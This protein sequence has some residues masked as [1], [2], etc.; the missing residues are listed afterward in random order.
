MSTCHITSTLGC[1]CKPGESVRRG[2]RSRPQDC[3]VVWSGLKTWLHYLI[4]S[5]NVKFSAGTRWPKLRLARSFFGKASVIMS[6]LRL[7]LWH[8]MIQV[9]VGWW[10]VD[11]GDHVPGISLNATDPPSFVNTSTSNGSSP[12][13][14]STIRSWWFWQDSSDWWFGADPNVSVT[15]P[16]G[17]S[18]PLEGWFIWGFRLCAWVGGAHVFSTP[19][20]GGR[21][22]AHG[23]W[24][25]FIM[26][27]CG[28]W[29]F[30]N[31]WPVVGTASCA[32]MFICM[33]GLTAWSLHVL[34]RFWFCQC[35]RAG[36]RRL[37][38]GDAGPEHEFEETPV[39]RAFQ[40]LTLTG[41]FG[42][43]AADT[44]FY[45]KGVRGRGINRK[46]HDLVVVLDSGVA[47]LQVDQERRG[48][49]DSHDLWVYYFR[50]L[51]VTTRNVGDHLEKAQARLSISANRPSV[52]AAQ[53]FTAGR[54]LRSTRRPWWILEP[55][56][57]SLLG[58]WGG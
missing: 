9:G 10:F 3:P 44:E 38:T 22:K 16:E 30:G 35:L 51:S 49:I 55:T 2:L 14:D 7:C 25:F 34:S 57:V 19:A 32:A 13:E 43:R 1:A 41:P 20:K 56:A 33:L 11:Q 24:I 27:T 39:V 6:P 52:R 46:P 42:V 15:P 18:L 8:S 29:M 54:M 5:N 12:P 4:V 37:C 50:V 48:R 26:D 17:E 36:L 31:W 58:D 21:L 53:E 40:A 28:V 23:G 47:R 45:N